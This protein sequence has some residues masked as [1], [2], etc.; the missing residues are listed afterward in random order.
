MLPTLSGTGR[1]TADPEL[2]FSPSGTA[3]AKVNLAFNSRKKDQQ[4]NWVDDQVC[5]LTATAFN[6]LAE[7]LVETVSKGTEV[8]VTGRL[9]TRQ[10]EDKETGAKR[11]APELI[12]DSIGPNLAFATANVQKNARENN[13]QQRGGDDPWATATPAGNRSGGNSFQDDS[14]PF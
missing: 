5:F 9:Q 2:R 7:N 14:P 8:V 6:R 10:W 4:G 12:I 11:S 1:A 3:V 13:S